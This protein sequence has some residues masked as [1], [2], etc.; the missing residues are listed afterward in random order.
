MQTSVLYCLA[1]AWQ[2]DHPKRWMNQSVF[3]LKAQANGCCVAWTADATLQTDV[4][5]A[6]QAGVDAVLDT[7]VHPGGEEDGNRCEQGG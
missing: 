7:A 6:K 4:H 3:Y 5:E 2:A 1:G